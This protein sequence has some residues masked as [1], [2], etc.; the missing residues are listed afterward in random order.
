VA[1]RADQPAAPPPDAGGPGGPGGPGHEGP[2]GPGGR[3][4]EGGP[5]GR[6][7]QAQIGRMMT[8][9][10]ELDLTPEEHHQIHQIL[11]SHHKDVVDALHPVVLKIRALRNAVTDPSGNE[12]A[13]RAASDDLGK[14][15]GDAAVLGAKI[16]AEIAGVLTDD[17]RHKLED[18]RAATD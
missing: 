2:G 15:I 5:L 17:Q 8:L 10:A 7:I 9:R 6:L 3:W 1:V 18:F 12:Q 11:E 4:G 16:K 14:S 13:I